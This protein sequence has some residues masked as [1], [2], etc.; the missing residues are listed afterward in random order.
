LGLT[1]LIVCFLHNVTTIIFA[2]LW[3]ALD[4]SIRYLLMAGSRYHTANATLQLLDHGDD[5]DREIVQITIA[6]PEG[7]DYSPGQFVQLSVPA[8]SLF[9]YHPVSI[10]SAPHEDTVTFQFRALGDWTSDIVA[11]AKSSESK[12]TTVMMEGPYGSLA[13][14]LDD[15]QRYKTVLLVGGGIGATHCESVGKALLHDNQV[16]GRQLTNLRY[17]WTVRKAGM[18]EDMPP[19]GGHEPALYSP[20]T[21]KTDAS[22]SPSP[23]RRSTTFTT[24]VNNDFESGQIT[25]PPPPPAR[26]NID[27]YCTREDIEESTGSIR[28]DE[29]KATRYHF[30]I[31]PD[32]DAIFEE[33]KQTALANGESNIAV[34]GCGPESMINTLRDAC[35]KHSSSVVGCGDQF[36]FFDFH[37][38]RFE[39]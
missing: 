12:Q 19:L 38:E 28:N 22:A 23:I 6:K 8:I 10:S 4:V 39:F 1:A 18:V 20:G 35:R 37:T 9:Q 26:V 30:G 29:D 31:R 36:V 33:M 7:F 17:I 5:G 27:I 24:A 11:L 15:R 16:N 13:V 25:I 2:L 14:D 3:W 34:I 32:L 21:P